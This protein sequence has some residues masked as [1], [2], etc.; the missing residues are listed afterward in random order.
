MEFRKHL[1]E[2]K[3]LGYTVL[4]VFRHRFEKCEHEFD[5]RSNWIGGYQ[6]GFWFKIN[7]VVGKRGF[8]NPDNWS[9]NT[10]NEYMI[11]FHGIIFKSW[12]TIQKGAMILNDK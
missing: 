2:F 12:I 8:K 7:R 1:V 9:K 4:V 11:G 10:I 6:L 3:M 5:R